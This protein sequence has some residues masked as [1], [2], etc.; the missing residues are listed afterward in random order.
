M[1]NLLSTLEKKQG[2]HRCIAIL[3]A[4]IRVFTRLVAPDLV[5]WDQ[6]TEQPLG[7]V[8]TAAPKGN[9]RR[10]A[11][12]R[13]L[14][15]EL[16][17]RNGG[18]SIQ[19]LWDIEGSFDHL[20]LAY[21][22]E[23]AWLLGMD[24][25]MLA[26]FLRLHLAPR[27]LEVDGCLAEPMAILGRSILMGCTSSTRL[28]R[29]AT[30]KPL[31]DSQATP[32]DQGVTLTQGIHVD[33]VSQQVIGQNLTSVAQS[34]VRAASTLATGIRRMGLRLSPK[35]HL[36]ASSHDLR[37]GLRGRLGHHGSCRHQAQ[38]QARQQ[39]RTPWQTA[40]R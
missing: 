35:S 38:G 17:Q 19:L 15:A 29:A 25:D 34:A 23:Q 40:G 21:V 10:A 31:L 33:D 22:A 28:G 14:R 27:V 1:L 8:D 7:T 2:G 4:V 3:P 16:A 11:V 18:Y 20:D 36:V 12:H 9:A 32:M 39:T 30:R 37:R 24:A 13:Q 5:E 26:V 6:G